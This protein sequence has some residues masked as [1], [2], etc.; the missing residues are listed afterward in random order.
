MNV[1]AM[2]DVWL[3]GGGRGNAAKKLNKVKQ[4]QNFLFS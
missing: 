2:M 1:G 3:R 4:L